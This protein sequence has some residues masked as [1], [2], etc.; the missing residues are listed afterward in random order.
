MSLTRKHLMILAAI[1]G[2]MALTACT[3][4]ITTIVQEEPQPSSCFECHSD[5]D[6]A[7][8]VS[9]THLTLPTS[10]LV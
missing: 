6:L 10:D 7:V 3:R 9:Y 2:L 5:T 1:V 4:E 8:P